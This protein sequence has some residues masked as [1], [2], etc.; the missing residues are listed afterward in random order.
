MVMPWI[1]R[2]CGE[3]LG[4]GGLERDTWSVDFGGLYSFS[5][6]DEWGV[7]REGGSLYRIEVVVEWKLLISWTVVLFC[8]RPRIY[9]RENKKLNSWFY[10]L[11]FLDIE[12]HE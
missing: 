11:Y 12:S 7:A 2:R 6:F 3:L 5:F 8:Y 10:N 1:V 4:V 9:G